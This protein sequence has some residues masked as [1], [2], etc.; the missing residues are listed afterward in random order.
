MPDNTKVLYETAAPSGVA[1]ALFGMFKQDEEMAQYAKKKDID[2][3]AAVKLKEQENKF[4]T[5]LS[6]LN[7]RYRL[8]L[9]DKE[10]AIAQSNLM[11]QGRALAGQLGSAANTVSAQTGQ[12]ILGLNQQGAPQTPGQSTGEEALPWNANP[13]DPMAA[14]A[15][16]PLFGKA[17]DHEFRKMEEKTK[18]DFTDKRDLLNN[19]LGFT[20][21]SQQKGAADLAGLLESIDP[22]D[23]RIPI[24]RALAE[25]G[26]KSADWMAHIPKLSQDYEA[27]KT[28]LKKIQATGQ[29]RKELS[30]EHDNRMAA[31][32]QAL[33]T[34]KQGGAK[35]KAAMIDLEREHRSIAA[36]MSRM[37]AE[38]NQ[39][40]QNFGAM[41]YKTT[42]EEDAA[43][44]E[45]KRLNDKIAEVGTGLSNI[46]RVMN[47]YNRDN[48]PP[49]P[50]EVA[51]DQ[52]KK[53][54]A[55]QKALGGKD[56]SKL[57]QKERD[58][59]NL[60]ANRLY[61]GGK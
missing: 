26:T 23:A 13:I 27:S 51:T 48:M 44:I 31:A 22:K 16:L 33:A 55:F 39:I 35:A 37:Q 12:P 53:Q 29:F 1:D 45:Q 34:I 5:S 9:V 41:V 49:G 47:A 42:A 25:P 32:G 19:K 15:M 59:V 30:A 21:V 57:N 24:A 40:T 4:Q 61:N 7:Q 58:A 50:A 8:D 54:A 60:E 38:S 43:R 14:S 36:N 3:N 17:V 46:E 18:Q 11:T 56:P 52:A 2:T 10:N 28:A 6:M 20:T